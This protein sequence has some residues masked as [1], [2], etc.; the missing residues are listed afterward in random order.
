MPL[1]K[2]QKNFIV[3]LISLSSTF[4]YSC[5]SVGP[6]SNK[7]I[8]EWVHQY[9]FY[10]KGQNFASMQTSGFTM[11]YETVTVLEKGGH[12]K[13]IDK[14]ITVWDDNTRMQNTS[15][16]IEYSI[17]WETK[18]S[19]QKYYLVRQYSAGKV[20]DIKSDN[21]LKEEQDAINVMNMYNGK[22]DTLYFSI[23]DDNSVMWHLKNSSEEYKMTQR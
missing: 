5:N 19:D 10:T 7:L 21:R 13:V 3:I 8:G 2:T 20:T 15:R 22:S 11:S 18:N 4:Y 14:L 9:S 6:K 16:T 17:K 12:G 23:Q 1:S